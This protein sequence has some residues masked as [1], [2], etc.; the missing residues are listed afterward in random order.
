MGDGVSLSFDFK[1]NKKINIIK[2][3]YLKN[4]KKYGYSFYFAKDCIVSKSNFIFN[5]EFYKFKKKINTINNSNKIKSQLSSS[6]QPFLTI[7][8]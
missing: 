5:E 3:F 6:I 4:A 7:S 2:K 8:S 1:V